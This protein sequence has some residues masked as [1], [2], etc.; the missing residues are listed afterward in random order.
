MRCWIALIIS[1]GFNNF[2][3]YSF[4]ENSRAYQVTCDFVGISLKETRGEKCRCVFSHLNA[5]SYVA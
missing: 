5:P 4:D 1:F 3:A 2:A